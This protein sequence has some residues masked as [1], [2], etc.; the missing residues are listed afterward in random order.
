M[1]KMVYSHYDLTNLGQ[2]LDKKLN[3]KVAWV[4]GDDLMDSV[5]E[6]LRADVKHLDSENTS[7]KLAADTDSFLNDTGKPVVTCNAYLGARAITK[8]LREGADIIIC[9]YIYAT[10]VQKLRIDNTRRSCF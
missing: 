5:Q 4:S 3:L 1:H 7:V 10:Y 2:I 9:K 6:L 8:G